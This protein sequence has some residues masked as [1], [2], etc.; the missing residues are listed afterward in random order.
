MEQWEA[1]M[2]IGIELIFGLWKEDAIYSLRPIDH[3][4]SFDYINVVAKAF[5]ET[6]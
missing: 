3:T 2:F 1:Q 5:L 4:L 6:Q